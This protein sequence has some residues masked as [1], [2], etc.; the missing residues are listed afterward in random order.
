MPVRV[1]V[2]V[3]QT[4]LG[5]NQLWSRP[6]NGTDASLPRTTEKPMPLGGALNALLAVIAACGLG[7]L[8]DV[9]SAAP[10]RLSGRPGVTRRSRRVPVVRVGDRPCPG[11]RNARRLRFSRRRNRSSHHGLMIT[12]RD[13]EILFAN[14]AY[15]ARLS[16]PTPVAPRPARGR[17][18]RRSPGGRMPVPA[19][20]GCR[21]GRG[22]IRGTQGPRPRGPQPRGPLVAPRRSA[23]AR[24]R[25]APRNG[26]IHAMDPRRHLE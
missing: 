17:I 11:W 7:A 16:A 23:D 13:G 5:Q 9:I 20:A 18:R 8:C 10:S 26:R 21:T 19:V 15:I 25:R 14:A 12:R 2:A 3:L 22:Q 24:P 1:I 4:L 6:M